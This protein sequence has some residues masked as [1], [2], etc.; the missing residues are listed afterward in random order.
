[1]TDETKTIEN[2]VERLRFFFS[3]ANLRRDKFMR[4]EL[5]ENDGKVTIESLLRFNSIK[6]HTEDAAVVAKA[7]KDAS[8]AD[9]IKLSEDE[10]SIARVVPFDMETMGSGVKFSIRVSNIPTEEVDGVAKYKVTRDEVKEMFDK[11]GPVALINMQHFRKSGKIAAIG[12]AIIEYETVEA[13]EKAV[14]DLV[15]PADGGED[16]KPANVIKIGDNELAVQTLEKWIEKKKSNKSPSKRGKDDAEIEVEYKKYE[17]E[18]EKGRVISV[19]GVPEGCDREKIIAAIGA[20]FD[21]EADQVNDKLMA[22]V[23]YS[24]GQS[25]AA[26]RFKEANDKIQDFAAKLADGTV[27]IDDA[28]VTSAAILEGEE[29]EKYYKDFI[30]FKNMHRKKQAM[31]KMSNK[32][33][34]SK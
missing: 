34:R 13:K 11:Y 10:K 27:K 9:R 25:D 18:W 1:M 19:K 15:A 17:L 24:R 14:A 12:A 21:V 26:I 31:E 5:A 29:E 28:A 22:Y 23:D 32:R 16:A 2:V 20:F 3:D 8:L 30:D 6:Q 4:N 33:R 7:A